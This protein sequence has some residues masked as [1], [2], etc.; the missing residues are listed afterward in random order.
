MLQ[1]ELFILAHQCGDASFYPTYKKMIQDQWKPYDELRHEQ[2]GRL[3][4]L[5]K[6]SYENIPYYHNLFKSLNRTPGDIRTINDLEKLP[7]LTKEIIKEHWGEFK[8][9]KLSSM[10]YYSQATGGSTG[11]PMQY[12]LSK[13][14]RFMGGA[15][16][17]RGWGYGGYELGDKMVFLAGSSL[18]VGTKSHLVKKIHEV[19]RNIRMLSSFDMGG[20]QMQRYADILGSFRPRFIRGYA[21]SIYFFARWLEEK[22]ISIPAPEGVFTTSEKLFPHMRKKI[23]DIFDCDVY[24]NYGLNDG[25]ISA[26]E[27]SE[28]TGLHIDMER[29]LMEVID[30]DGSQI[31]QG[32]GQIL[33]TSLHNYAM[34]FIRYVTGDKGS[35]LDEPCSCGRDYPLLKEVAGRQQEMLV[36]PEGKHIHGEFFTHIFWE[37]PKVKEFQIVQASSEKL[38]IKLVTEPDFNEANLESIKETIRLRSRGWDVEFRFVDSIDRSHAG[39]YKFVINEVSNV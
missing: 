38:I 26:F 16:L 6:F 1:K 9:A 22:Q 15:L 37:V 29:G 35:L 23:S 21:S 18:D 24:D 25:S 4:N 5:I 14:D 3:R 17:Y 19:S 27:C 28:H 7:I 11:T 32:E 34:P 20:P 12:R 10:K 31:E 36:T 8:P 2:E 13:F 33:A 30:D 39:K